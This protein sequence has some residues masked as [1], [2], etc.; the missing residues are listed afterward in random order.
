MGRIFGLMYGV[1]LAVGGGGGR[2]LG[3][4]WVFNG[5]CIRCGRLRDV[6][7][8]F[9]ALGAQIWYADITKHYPGKAR[10]KSLAGT[11]FTKPGAQVD[12]C[13]RSGTHHKNR[14]VYFTNVEQLSNKT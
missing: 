8:R 6:S 9:C 1:L 14:T 4:I 2:G 13:T 10:Q 3:V 5:A 11:N 7:L 12:L